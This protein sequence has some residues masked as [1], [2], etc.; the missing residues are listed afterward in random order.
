MIDLTDGN[1]GDPYVLE[2]GSSRVIGRITG[3]EG[4]DAFAGTN[5]STRPI[6]L[7]T[8]P[9]GSTLKA[10][11]VWCRPPTES[12]LAELAAFEEQARNNPKVGVLYAGKLDE[13]LG[14]CR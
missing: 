8:T 11:R 2:K 7:L 12:E 6:L 1:I 10:G 9:H 13:D 3:Y 5:P 14:R 4:T